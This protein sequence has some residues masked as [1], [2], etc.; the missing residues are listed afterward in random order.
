MEIIGRV[1]ADAKI[2]ELKDGR[3]VVNFS[4]AINDNYRA[5]GSDNINK[6]VTYFKCTYWQNQTIAGYLTKGSLV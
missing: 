2:N 1:T 6:M 5:K 4:V 3:K